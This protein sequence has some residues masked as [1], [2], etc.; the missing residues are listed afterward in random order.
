MRRFL[1]T[2]WF[3]F[4]ICLVLAAVTAAAYAG[5]HPTGE[6]IGNSELERISTLAAWGIG[7]I[8]GLLSLILAGILNLIRRLVR[9]RKIAF[10]HPVVVLVSVG[11]WMIF[12]WQLTGEPRYTPIA[13]AVIDFAARELLWGSLV[14]VLLTIILSIPLL[15]PAKK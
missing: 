11:P 5:L 15:F 13:R 3:P 9:A 6:D 8:A 14:A 4:L 1:A 10:L 2:A 12:S 7:P